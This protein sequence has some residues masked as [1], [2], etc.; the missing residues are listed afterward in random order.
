MEYQGRID[1]EIVPAAETAR[2][3]AEMESYGFAD[4]KHGLVAF[5][6]DG[7]PLVKIPGHNYGKEEIV[8]AIKK[9]L[10]HDK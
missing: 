4:A 9:L 1:F 3:R 8:A 5:T 6:R 2:R 10:A 7:E